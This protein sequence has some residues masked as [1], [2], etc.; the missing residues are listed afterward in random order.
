MLFLFSWNS[1]IPFFLQETCLVHIKGPSWDPS[2]APRSAI[3]VDPSRFL[4]YLFGPNSLPVNFARLDNFSRT[5]FPYTVSI[6]Y[7]DLHWFSCFT[8]C[9]TS[10]NEY[11]CSSESTGGV[12]KV[13]SRPMPPAC[14]KSRVLL[15]AFQK[16]RGDVEVQN[17]Y[18]YIVNTE[19][20]YS[21]GTPNCNHT[22]SC[23]YS[24][25]AWPF[26]QLQQ[27]TDSTHWLL[28]WQL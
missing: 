9:F 28:S 15:G 22:I 23:L 24:P 12:F 27:S 21:S 2:S 8:W 14:W 10:I 11:F 19:S 5:F 26:W 17:S 6:F 7:P 13:R 1:S 20:H 4:S 3:H 25:N 18:S 16:E